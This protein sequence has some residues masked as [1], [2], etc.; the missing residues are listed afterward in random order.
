MRLLDSLR[1]TLGGGADE[2]GRDDLLQKVE[3]GVLA[4]RRHGARGREVFPDGVR[5]RITAAEGSIATLRGFVSDASFERD[6]EARLTNRLVK[7]EALPARRYEVVQ[8]DVPGVTVEDDPVGLIGVLVIEGGDKDAARYVM[9]LGRK[10]WRLGR[11]PWHQERADDQRLPN[12][13]ILSDNLAYVSR[14]AAILRRSG[15]QLEVESR[16]Q[17]EFLIV[18]RKDG[19]QLRPAMTASGRV[20]LKVGDRMVFHDGRNERLTVI[21]LPV[22][23]PC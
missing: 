10:E 14:A 19:A 6:L 11:G 4:L 15:A 18:Q 17:G 12:D 1:K 16:Q 8:G 5:V 20:P 21:L 7:P 2:L 23:E 3:D 9:E 13:L 22:E